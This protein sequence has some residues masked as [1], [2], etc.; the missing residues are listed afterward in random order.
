MRRL[1]GQTAIVTGAAQGLGR[2]YAR[3]LAE[4]GANVSVCDLRDSVAELDPELRALGVEVLAETCDVSK[5][6][7][8]AAFVARTHARFGRIDIL[9]ANAGVVVITSP[10]DSIDKTLAD[11]ETEV[12]TNLRGIF[13]FGRAVI[14]HMIEQGR[15][16]ILN[17]ST[18]HVCTCGAPIEW[19]HDDAPDCPYKDA[20]RP[21]GG[22]AVMDLYDS[23]KW[24][25]NGLTF[26][27][28]RALRL[29]GIRVNAFCMGATDTPMLREFMGDDVE[30]AVVGSWMRPEAI[31]QVML[32][33]FGEGPDGRT[34]ENIGF[35]VG[36][37]VVLPSRQEPIYL[38]E[39]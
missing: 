5:A 11:Y 17:I 26:A 39:Q 20:P 4:A 32:E 8:V 30:P 2:A 13:L 14:P 10:M 12:G 35:A 34:G 19:S 23:S 15:G 37:P 38:R 18:D 31:A 1:D 16:E 25:I 28:S 21:T 24:G 3:A 27:W 6:D 9:V 33:L 29:H 36:H 22:G 7:Q